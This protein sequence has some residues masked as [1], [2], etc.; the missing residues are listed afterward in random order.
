MSPLGEPLSLLV[1]A[2]LGGV[3]AWLV[4]RRLAAADLARVA[5]ETGGRAAA[6]EA[7][8]TALLQASERRTA[9]IAEQLRVARETL[10]AR[11]AELRE[12]RD[13][14]T[15]GKTEAAT[16]DTRLAELTRAQAQ[17]KDAFQS[18]CGEA[19]RSNNE[20]FLQLA[21]T[22][23]ER[24][25]LSAQADLAEKETAIQSLVTP[26]RDGLEKYDRKLHDI[27]LARAE[28]FASLGARIDG[29]VQVSDVLRTETANLAKALRS[30]NVRGAWGELQLERAV[31]LAGMI[32]HCDFSTQHSVAGDD[33]TLRP[34]M[35][36]HLPGDKTI[37]VDA[38]TPATAVLEAVNCTDDGAR[39]ELCLQFVVAVKKHI[40]ALSRKAYWEQFATAPEFVVLFLP[41]EAFFSV[42]LEFDPTLFEHAFES[43][44]IIAT[45]TTLVAVLKAVAYGWRQESLAR[46]AQEISELGKELYERIRTMAE[47][48][49]RVGG[50]LGKSV[51]AYND[52]VGSLERRVLPQARRFQSLGVG[53]TKALEELAAVDVA[54]VP[55]LA[56]ELRAAV[57]AEES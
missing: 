48:F 5:S 47:H 52:A 33:G 18:L 16:F 4:A 38:K 30:S 53:S 22:E 50:H 12:A 6:R 2:L 13:E 26:I 37:V 17:L 46:N 55:L 7:E 11:D 9:D 14:I 23:L 44:V 36:V 21:R 51:Q 49:E 10:I 45:P 32:E 20:Q 43:Q 57:G 54:P 28:S 8:L 39:R 3:L 31:E 42:A 35:V 25:R 41:S 56:A 27:E 1:S 19:L 24:V 34:D 40:E 29:V 15:R